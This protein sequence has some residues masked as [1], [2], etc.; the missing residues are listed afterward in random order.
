MDQMEKEIID[1]L[2][3]IEERCSGRCNLFTEM[4]EDIDMIRREITSLKDKFWAFSIKLM[5]I[6]L[7]GG[8]GAAALFKMFGG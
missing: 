3:R 8:G 5:L 7:A 2:A 1:R 4:S 6:A